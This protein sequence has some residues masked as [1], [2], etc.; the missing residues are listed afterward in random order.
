M[1]TQQKG[2]K[3]RT[4]ILEVLW[5]NLF[6]IYSTIWTPAIFQISLQAMG[7]ISEKTAQKNGKRKFRCGSVVTNPTSL[8]EALLGGR[9]KK[10]NFV[11]AQTNGWRKSCILGIVF[12]KVQNQN[13]GILT[14]ESGGLISHLWLTLFP[15]L[16]WVLLWS[17]WGKDKLFLMLKVVA[18]R[19]K[20]YKMLYVLVLKGHLFGD[21]TFSNLSS[22]RVSCSFLLMTEDVIE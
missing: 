8:H 17:V 14:G 13:I 21:P 11:Y 16:K 12:R 10:W 2:S 3:V 22:C 1:S 20:C 7:Y 6:I 15:K 19:S 4:F 9:E 5:R 18:L